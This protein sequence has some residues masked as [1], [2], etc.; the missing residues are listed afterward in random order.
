MDNRGAGGACV[1]TH[2]NLLRAGVD[3][4]L[5]VVHKSRPEIP[6]SRSF[7][8][9]MSK[10]LLSKSINRLKIE[11][12]RKKIQGK[13]SRKPK[14]GVPFSF[15]ISAYDIT[16]HPSYQDADIIT[17]HWAANFLDFPS[18]FAKNDKP[19]TWRMPDMFPFTGGNHYDT[20]FP[21]DAYQD[22]LKE[23]LEIK[24]RALKNCKIHPIPLCKWMN[25]LSQE[26]PLFKTYSHT[27]IPNGLDTE[28][29]QPRNKAFSREVLG[30]PKNA[31]ILLFVSDG[32][33]NTRKGYSLLL[34]ALKLLDKEPNL[35]LAVLGSTHKAGISQDNMTLFGHIHDERLLS[36]AY[37]AAD[38]YVIPSIE[39]NLPN[40]V[41]ESI[42]CGTPVVG[43]NIGG[44]P[45]M[46]IHGKNGLLCETISPSELAKTILEASETGFDSTE[47]RMDAVQRFDQ[48][49]QAQKYIGLYEQLMGIA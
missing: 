5:L 11:Q 47:I 2:M 27:I 12:L 31:R 28:V 40:T 7:Y 8:E 22:L 38:L 32:I 35:H 19:I 44:V 36:I 3:S 20:G 37:S 24:G 9:G 23:N 26:S 10:S 14:S 34:D 49:V 48:S 41:I 43:F 25:D 21:R 6:N 29:F 42:A 39:D 33:E 13:L 1:R 30:L 18:F 15:P 17:F 16:R 46:L 45:D 4:H